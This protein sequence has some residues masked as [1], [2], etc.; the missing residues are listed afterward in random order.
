[1]EEK[2]DEIENIFRNST[3]A[4]LLFD[5]F[6][7][8]I[9]LKIENPATFKILLGNP[10][11]SADEIKMFVEKLI[12]EYPGYAYELSIWAAIIFEQKD[13]YL[14]YLEEAVHYYKKAHDYKP[15]LFVSLLNLLSLYNYELNLP[16]NKVILEFVE[17][18]VGGVQTKSKIYYALADHYKKIGDK[19][20]E[21][22]YFELA[23][24]A[25]E[26]ENGND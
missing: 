3:S 5:A 26:I 13:D 6:Q 25:S 4:D 15:V 2:L 9:E 22:K 23:E 17:T 24:R 14:N 11:L 16:I 10:A 19:Q 18:R 7:E 12:K 1:M 21:V 20:T 8:A